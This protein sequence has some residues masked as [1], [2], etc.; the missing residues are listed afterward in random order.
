MSLGME[1]V[2]KPIIQRNVSTPAEKAALHFPEVIPE[3]LA[4][5]LAPERTLKGDE[6]PGPFESGEFRGMNIIGGAFRAAHTSLDCGTE[7][8]DASDEK[9]EVIND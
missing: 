3:A 5:V 2:T 4:A 6:K 8:N 7:T 1:K 9:C